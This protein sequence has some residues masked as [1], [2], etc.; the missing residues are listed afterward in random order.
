MQIAKSHAPARKKPPKRDRLSVFCFRFCLTFLAAAASGGPR[1]FVVR[2]FLR[3]KELALQPLT[4]SIFVVRPML[5][6]TRRQQHTVCEQCE[7]TS[8]RNRK[9]R[10]RVNSNNDGCCESV[11]TLFGWRMRVCLPGRCYSRGCSNRL[12]LLYLLHSQRKQ[13]HHS[14][15]YLRQPRVANRL[16]ANARWHAWQPRGHPG[17]P[18]C[19]QG[20]SQQQ[21]GG[22]C[23][24]RSSLPAWTL[25]TKSA[26]PTHQR[27]TLPCFWACRQSSRNLTHTSGASPCDKT[28]ANANPQWTCMPAVSS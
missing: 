27:D 24:T 12:L 1:E 6:Q 18:I 20:C 8:S 17:R 19:I 5:S 28:S 23:A 13:L 22:W 3:L 4:Q 15:K 9:Y 11:C 25:Q 10:T 2:E 26:S 7:N 16:A 21:T 14:T